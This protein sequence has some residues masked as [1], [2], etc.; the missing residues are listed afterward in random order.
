MK[1]PPT[2]RPEVAGISNCDMF[3]AADA[4][5]PELVYR[6]YLRTC[7]MCGVEPD[8]QRGCRKRLQTACPGSDQVRVIR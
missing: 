6:N 3:D 7:A 1:A 4:P 5:D 2:R 8:A